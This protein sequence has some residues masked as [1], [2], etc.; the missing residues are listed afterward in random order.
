MEKAYSVKTSGKVAAVFIA[1]S[2]S[3]LMVGILTPLWV[4]L[5]QKWLVVYAP[6]A[7]YSGVFFY[8]TLAW[9]VLWAG[10]YFT[11]GRKESEG[12]AKRWMTMFLASLIAATAIIM[13]SL[14]WMPFPW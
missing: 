12:T 1:T 2:A 10:L 7:G 4:H 13:A 3:I 5:Q 11:L 14:P 6:A 8:P 9:A